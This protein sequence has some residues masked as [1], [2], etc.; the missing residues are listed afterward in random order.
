MAEGDLS[1]FVQTQSGGVLIYLE[2]RLP[3]DEAAFE[4]EKANTAKQIVQ[5]KQEA[6]IRDWIEARRKAAN[7]KMGVG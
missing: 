2:K 4:K 5:G 3:I 1:E 7:L 6:L